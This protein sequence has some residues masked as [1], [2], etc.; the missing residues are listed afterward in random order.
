ML[1]RVLGVTLTLILL[2]LF[3][4]NFTPASASQILNTRIARLES[5]NVQLRSRISRLESRI[6]RITGSGPRRERVSQPQ[7][8]RSTLPS[9]ASS[10]L[11]GDDPM[12]KRLATLVIELK[13]RVIELETRLDEQEKNLR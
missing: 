2:V 4:R 8:S 12:F 5:E 11:I 6:N 10:S 7:D 3:S 1:S 9:R 13:E